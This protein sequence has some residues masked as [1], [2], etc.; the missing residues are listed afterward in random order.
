MKLNQF[1]SH[2]KTKVMYKVISIKQ[3]CN[4]RI[5]QIGRSNL[6]QIEETDKSSWGEI[7]RA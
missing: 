3:T 2:L 1:R 7:K 5:K 6:K 4:R